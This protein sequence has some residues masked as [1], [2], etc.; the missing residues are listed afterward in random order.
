VED[1]AG[2]QVTKFITAEGFEANCLDLIDLVE[3]EGLT[4]DIRKDGRPLVMMAPA[5]PQKE[6]PGT[7]CVNDKIG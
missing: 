2:D 6:T 3:E 4:Y 7:S 1:Q 5:P